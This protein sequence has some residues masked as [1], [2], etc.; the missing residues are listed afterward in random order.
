[1]LQ[2]VCGC[3]YRVLIEPYWNVKLLKGILE[4]VIGEQVLIEPYWNVKLVTP[5]FKGDYTTY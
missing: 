3:Q 4:P 1:M 2:V 5:P